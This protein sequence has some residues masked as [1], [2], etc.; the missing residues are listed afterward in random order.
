LRLL[1]RRID[2]QFAKIVT[3]RILEGAEAEFRQHRVKVIENVRLNL[4]ERRPDGRVRKA[5]DFQRQAF[6]S[7][8]HLA[9]QQCHAFVYAGMIAQIIV[10]IGPK[11]TD[12]GELT[13]VDRIVGAVA[14]LLVPFGDFLGLLGQIIR[15]PI[16]CAKS[17]S[18]VI[19]QKTNG[20][21]I[22]IKRALDATPAGFLHAAIV[23][24]RLGDELADRN[25]GDRLVE[26]L[27]LDGIE[28]DF[29]DIAI[30]VEIL[31]FNPVADTNHVG[32]GDLHTGDQR[33]QCVL[34]DKD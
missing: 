26:I 18:L 7:R 15:Q 11:R 17:G 6:G 24:H 20:V 1:D 29:R 5:V 16:N 4:F 13:P 14:K 2:C 23:L 21:L 9:H 25:G 34:K 19:R 28:R 30:G 3:A 32:R 22:D 27:D 12:I 10:Y 33:K 31:H 8:I